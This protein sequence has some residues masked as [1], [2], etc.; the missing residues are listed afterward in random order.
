M[1]G[2]LD[3]G[4]ALELEALRRRLQVRARSGGGGEHV[5]KR[6][7]GSAEFLEHRAYTAGDDLR[8]MDWLAFARTG[9]PVLNLPGQFPQSKFEALARASLPHSRRYIAQSSPE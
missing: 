9:E 4:F 6:R 1:T 2:L 3:P 8:R 7:G 5:A